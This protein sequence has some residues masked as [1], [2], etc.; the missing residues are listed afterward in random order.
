MLGSDNS[1]VEWAGAGSGG[2]F[3][4]ASCA[5]P[6]CEPIFSGLRGAAGGAGEEAAGEG[7]L[8]AGSLAGEVGSVLIGSSRTLVKQCG[9]RPFEGSSHSNCAFPR[10]IASRRS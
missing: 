1:G 10:A 5:P 2:G 6:R 7:G 3:G 9:N 8:D 4:R